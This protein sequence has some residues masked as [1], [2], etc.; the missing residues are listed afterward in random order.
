MTVGPGGVAEATGE[1]VA[2]PHVLAPAA[3]ENALG[4]KQVSKPRKRKR[5]RSKAQRRQSTLIE[6]DKKEGQKKRWATRREKHAAGKTPAKQDTSKSTTIVDLLDDMANREEMPKVFRGLYDLIRPLLRDVRVDWADALTTK[7]DGKVT[8]SDGQYYPKRKRHGKTKGQ[9]EHIRIKRK[10]KE[11]AHWLIGLHEALHSLTYKKMRQYRNDPTSLTDRE[12]QAIYTLETLRND[13]RKRVLKGGLENLDL[14]TRKALRSIIRN[15]STELDEFL[16]ELMSTEGLRSYLKSEFGVDEN[17]NRIS[18]W[19]KL[20]DALARLVGRGSERA[21]GQ[22]MGE[23]YAL[24]GVEQGAPTQGSIGEKAAE[25]ATQ[26]VTQPEEP[27]KAE[28][29]RAEPVVEEPA[30]IGGFYGAVQESIDKTGEVPKAE[31]RGPLGRAWKYAQD[32][33]MDGKAFV[34]LVHKAQP[35]N[36]QDWKALEPQIDE[37]MFDPGSKPAQPEPKKA[38]V[39]EKAAE[40]VVEE[41]VVEPV[42]EPEVKKAPPKP[43]RKGTRKKSPKKRSVG[44]KA[45]GPKESTLPAATTAQLKEQGYTDD[46]ITHLQSALSLKDIKEIANPTKAKRP[47][48]KR[49]KKGGSLG[50]TGPLASESLEDMDEPSIPKDI[51]EA[52]G[53]KRD[54]PGGEWLV[55]ERRRAMAGRSHGSVTATADRVLV[56]IDKIGR[57][58]GQNDEHRRMQSDLSLAKVAALAT[59]IKKTGIKNGMEPLL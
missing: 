6:D 41:P 9:S 16:S 12:R 25:P 36:L 1:D 28:P 56:D 11:Q 2:Q 32:C 7:Q 18:L 48:K 5:K 52:T 21:L 55:H 45:E 46:G 15:R 59:S 24:I 57:V 39:G 10:P 8:N 26:T 30:E 43:K 34:A 19:D 31:Q 42:V 14:K 44:E 27:A 3:Q 17:G 23:L 35:K 58:P 47:K 20:L 4:E 37:A 13:L 53:Y 38:V 54:N 33:G 40:P 22:A 49:K 51:K 29:A 50:E